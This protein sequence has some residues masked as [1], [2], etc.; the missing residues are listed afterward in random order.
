MDNQ[1]KHTDSTEYGFF[2]SLH[3]SGRLDCIKIYTSESL[4]LPPHVL[5]DLK[6]QKYYFGSIHKNNVSLLQGN[7]FE[8]I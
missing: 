2:C 5:F 3:E 6:P 8:E 1:T 7:Q 4:E